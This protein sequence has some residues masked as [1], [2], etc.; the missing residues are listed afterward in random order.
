MTA[1]LTIQM[2]LNDLPGG[3]VVDRNA[4]CEHIRWLRETRSMIGESGHQ[5]GR[6]PV[7]KTVRMMR[8]ASKTVRHTT[9]EIR[10]N[11]KFKRDKV[12]PRWNDTAQ[13]EIDQ[14]SSFAV[15]GR[16]DRKLLLQ[17]NYHNMAGQ[18]RKLFSP[19]I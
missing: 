5:R 7:S 19:S 18:T 17:V 6:E 14:A 9:Q 13:V 8:T 3:E 1:R 2:I 16:P 12:R 11:M 10:Q 15:G 4:L